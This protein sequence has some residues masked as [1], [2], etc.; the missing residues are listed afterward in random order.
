[1]TTVELGRGVGNKFQVLKGLKA[2]DRVVIR[3]NERLGAGGRVK[4]IN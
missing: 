3:G 1:M 4:V 2:G